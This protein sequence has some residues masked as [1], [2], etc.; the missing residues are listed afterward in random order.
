MANPL[1]GDFE[2]V[3]Q[4]SGGTISR[5]VASMH[6]NA[7]A[8]PDVPSFPHSVSMRIGDGRAIDG[9]KGYVQAQI[10]VPLIQLIH[11][12]TDRFRLEVGVRAWYR[13]D[14]GTK[15]FPAFIHGTVRAE[16]H[17][18]DIDPTCPG[19]K[20]IAN[21]FM[22]VRVVKDSVRFEGTT[23]PDTSGLLGVDT[24]TEADEAANITKVTR[25]I[26]GLL[27]TQFVASPHR[28]TSNQFKRGRMRSLNAAGGSAVAIP[29]GLSSNVPVGNIAS[30]NT[31]LLEGADLAVGVSVEYILSIV[32]AKLAPFAAFTQTVAVHVDTP[33]LV[34]DIDTVYHAS[35]TPPVVTW[36]PQSSYAV[37]TVKVHGSAVTRSVLPNVVFDVDQKVILNFDAG[38]GRF[39]LAPGTLSVTVHASGFGSG[40]IIDAVQPHVTDAVRPL[41]TNACA[42]AQPEL[43]AMTSRTPAL[44]EQLRT[45]DPQASARLDRAQFVPA[46]IVARGTIGLGARRGPVVLSE[47]AAEQNGHSAFQSWI[48]GGRIDSLEWSWTWFTKGL[49]PGKA[50]HEDRFLLRRPHARPGRWGVS[51]TFTT[52]LPGIDG[53]GHVCLRITGVQVDANTG[54]LVPVQSVKQCTRF[55][56]DVGDSTT[57]EQK[58]FPRLLYR[59]P[60]LSLK[61]QFPERALVRAGAG[62]DATTAA[63]TLLVLRRRD[64]ESRDRPFIER[65][66]GR[67]PTVRR[68]TGP[69]RAVQRR[70]VG[71]RRAA[72]A[73]GDRGVRPRER[74]C[75]ARE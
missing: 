36:E 48:P 38:T 67:V 63:N 34:P 6:Q 75:R 56:I 28:V 53:S 57:L 35:V 21:L 44:T 11:G 72:V 51:A 13:P 20:R 16:Y 71:R 60:E 70:E 25:Q 68:G 41:V 69:A 24:T 54:Q 64:L 65:R 23:A 52:P 32:Q 27:A 58:P 62:H 9:V 66:L 19:W 26:A 18:Q 22:W 15:P 10:S 37:F 1:T 3:L 74:D 4:V 30:V 43:D 40:A 47:K 5:F 29:L 2:A 17:I 55:G 46:G 8:N 61:A 12:A 45:I 49:D 73:A 50:T 31:L 42:Q 7:F 33:P 59:E 14:Q 39:W